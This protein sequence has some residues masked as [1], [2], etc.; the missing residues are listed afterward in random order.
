MSKSEQGRAARNK[1]KRGELELA[2]FLSDQL[3]CKH[4]RSAQ[5]E[6]KNSADIVPENP[7]YVYPIH[8]ECKRV[9]KLNIYNAI[10]Q[11][12][13][14]ARDGYIP[15]VAHRRNGEEWLMTMP[16][17]YVVELSFIMRKLVDKVAYSVGEADDDGT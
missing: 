1:G 9:E 4:I 5:R 10:E 13:R 3:Y 15:V 2:H 12:T 14:D 11:A 8:W 7:E 6:G 17:K 16:L